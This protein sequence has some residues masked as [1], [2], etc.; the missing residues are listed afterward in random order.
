MHLLLFVATRTNLFPS[1]SLITL[2]E[3]ISPPISQ[4]KFGGLQSHEAF[5]VNAPSGAIIVI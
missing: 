3:A 5:K 2:V 1:N 4:R